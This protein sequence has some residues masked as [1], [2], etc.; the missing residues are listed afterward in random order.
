MK[1]KSRKMK[2]KKT[3]EE[4]RQEEFTK[5]VMDLR[6]G[7]VTAIKFYKYPDSVVMSTM[8]S[9]MGELIFLGI[10]HKDAKKEYEKNLDA[11]NALKAHMDGMVKSKLNK[12]DYGN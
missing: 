2:T 9:L 8:W 11:M 5:K 7:I 6:S 1:Q 10:E 12:V 4:I 3:K